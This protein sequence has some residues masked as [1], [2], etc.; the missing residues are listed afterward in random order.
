MRG[1]IEQ[2]ITRARNDIHASSPGSSAPLPPSAEESIGTIARMIN[3]ALREN[4]FIS[5]AFGATKVVLVLKAEEQRS[6]GLGMKL[7]GFS[8]TGGLSGLHENEDA[9]TITIQLHPV[10]DAY[11][12]NPDKADPVYDEE[13]NEFLSAFEQLNFLLV[14]DDARDSPILPGVEKTSVE[15]SFVITDDFKVSIVAQGQLKNDSAHQVIITL[16]QTSGPG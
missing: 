3:H 2:A 6:E 9:H 11:N 10:A 12:Q 1:F 13:K 7:S 14:D 8:I 5:A 16:G 15:L 4:G